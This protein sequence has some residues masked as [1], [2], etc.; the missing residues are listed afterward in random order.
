VSGAKPFVISK[1]QVIAIETAVFIRQ[2]FHLPLRQT[3][4]FMKSLVRIM[5]ADI[6]IPDFSRALLNK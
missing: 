3:E 5:K 4:G 6:T 2:V 1:W